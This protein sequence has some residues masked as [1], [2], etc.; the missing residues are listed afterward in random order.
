MV[1][2]ICYLVGWYIGGPIV[3]PHAAP[4]NNDDD[5]DDDD[6]DDCFRFFY[7]DL[8]SDPIENHDADADDDADAVPA[9]DAVHVAAFDS[10][11]N[12][13][14]VVQDPPED[15]I[16]LISAIDAEA[17][18]IEV[19]TE[20]TSGNVYADSEHTKRGK[21]YLLM[22]RNS[23]V[24]AG[25]EQINRAVIHVV[26]VDATSHA[27]LSVDM[28]TDGSHVPAEGNPAEEALQIGQFVLWNRCNLVENEED[29]TQHKKHRFAA[30]RNFLKA[31]QKQEKRYE[32]Q[33]GDFVL[34][35]SKGDTVGV[36]IHHADRTN[37]AA[38]L[39]PCKVLSC[40]EVGQ[41]NRPMYKVY[42]VAGV[43]KN[44][45]RAEELIDMRTVHF[46]ALQSV[47][48]LSLQDVSLIHA[49]RHATGW[50]TSAKAGTVCKCK[51]NCTSKRCCCRKAGVPCSTKCHPDTHASCKNT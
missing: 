28:V 40:K 29:G 41:G 47:D 35:Y 22:H 43:I 25:T 4:D 17:S 12:N 3:K 2:L 20:S 46:P 49:S 33:V 14:D 13:R 50:Q 27:V 30:R 21:E 1:I 39:L 23:I 37:T 36:K 45:F 7:L 34:L 11:E 19:H 51:G 10:L 32:R 48:Q 44:W 24:G 18:E 42:S 15:L 16:N 8:F 26:R 6:D 5:E 9:D 31:A 38:R